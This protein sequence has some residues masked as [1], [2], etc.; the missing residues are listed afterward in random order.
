MRE[1]FVIPIALPPRPVVGEP[2]PRE[3][4]QSPDDAFP[5]SP[6]PVDPSADKKKTQGEPVPPPEAKK[7]SGDP[8]PP[9]EPKKAPDDAVPLPEPKKLPGEQAPPEPKKA[10]G[11]NPPPEPTTPPTEQE[12]QREP[13][14]VPVVEIPAPSSVPIPPPLVPIPSLPDS[15]NGPSE[16]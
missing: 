8:A 7:T 3:A 5:P 10:P 4:N 14:S 1:R 12:T 13:V 2:L 9:A 11:E 6:T 15:K 16:R